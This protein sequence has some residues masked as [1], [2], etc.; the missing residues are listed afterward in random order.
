MTT[1]RTALPDQLSMSDHPD[2]VELRERLDRAA[3]TPQAWAIDGLAVLAGLYA[4][5]SPWVVDFNTGNASLTASNL[6]VG[7]AAAALA[8]ELGSAYSRAHGIGWI[9]PVLGAWIIVS[10]WVIQSTVLDAGVV[11]N[12]IIA[13][14]LI[15]LLGAGTVGMQRMRRPA[16]H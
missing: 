16:R 14:A 15:V 10:Q 7:L 4:A 8:L 5:I 1:E 11:V 13:G 3:E 12:N 9:L 6:I 2:M